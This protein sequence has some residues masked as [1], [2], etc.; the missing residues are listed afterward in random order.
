MT[1]NRGRRREKCKFKYLKNFSELVWNAA[2]LN[3]LK[4]RELWGGGG[5]NIQQQR[6]ESLNLTV[7]ST[8]STVLSA[9][10]SVVLSTVLSTGL[11]TVLSTV[12]STGLFTVARY[13]NLLRDLSSR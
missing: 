5:T 12:L 11:S 8:L 13:V 3:L 10:L 7:R 9:V 1:G 4:N 2:L 6:S